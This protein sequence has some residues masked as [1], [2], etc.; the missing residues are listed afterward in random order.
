M[1]SF[2]HNKETGKLELHCDKAFYAALTDAQKQSIKSAFLWGRRSGCWISRCKEP[3]LWSAEQVAK[4]LG[5]ANAGATGERLSFAEQQELKAEKAERRAD[6]LC[7]SALDRRAGAAQFLG[8][9][10]AL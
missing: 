1:N 10:R 2:V 4:A 5:L 6:E 8:R 7:G 3:N 9:R